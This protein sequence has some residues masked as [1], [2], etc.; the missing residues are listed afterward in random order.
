MKTA[1]YIEEGIVQLVIT[2]Q[3][4]FEKNALSSFKDKPLDAKVYSGSFYDCRGVWTRQTEVYQSMQG[5]KDNSDQ[6]L[7]LRMTQ[8]EDDESV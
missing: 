4:E 1:I 8:G 5:L 6:S 7:I 3:N 2:P